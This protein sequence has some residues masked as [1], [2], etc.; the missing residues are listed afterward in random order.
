MFAELRSYMDPPHAVLQVI[1]ALLYIM[2]PEEEFDTWADCK[3][4]S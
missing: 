4:V 1:R 2:Y 3:P